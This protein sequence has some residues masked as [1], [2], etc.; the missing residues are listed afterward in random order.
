MIS[1]DVRPKGD[2]AELE[3]VADFYRSRATGW[4]PAFR[5][6]QVKVWSNALEGREAPVEEWPEAKLTRTRTKNGETIA[7]YVFSSELP[8]EVLRHK[9]V[10]EVAGVA[11]SNV[12]GEYDGQDYGVNFRPGYRADPKREANGEFRHIDDARLVRNVAS[13]KRLGKAALADFGDQSVGSLRA[14]FGG[15]SVTQI[16]RMTQAARGVI[17]GAALRAGENKA[18]VGTM[19]GMAAG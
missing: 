4:D 12:G 13:F 9:G 18:A 14:L 17:L 16:A 3:V 8:K 11:T 5:S 7:R 6:E 10:V 15:A 1:V 19:L 2:Q